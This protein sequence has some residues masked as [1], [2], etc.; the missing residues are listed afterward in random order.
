MTTGNEMSGETPRWEPGAARNAVSLGRHR[1]SAALGSKRPRA[2]ARAI[3]AGVGGQRSI[4]S[5]F[6]ILFAVPLISLVALYAYLASGTAGAAFAKRDADTVN[7]DLGSPSSSLYLQL[8][9]ERTDTLVWQSAHGKVPETGLDAQ[10]KLTDSAVAAFTAA[11][12]AARGAEPPAGQAAVAAVVEK[13]GAV[14]GIRK[15]VDAGTVAPLTAFQAYNNVIDTA[16][17]IAVGALTNPDT[18]V[19]FYEQGL[20]TG[21]MGQSL[22]YVDREASLVGGALAAG[23]TMSTA[24]YQLFLEALDEQ[25]FLERAGQTPV[26]WQQYPD[27]YP[28]VFASPAYVQFAGLEDKI[29]AA[30]PGVRL[31]VSAAGWQA[32][33]GKFVPLLLRAEVTSRQEVT[34]GSTHE[35]NVTLLRLILV[36]GA[37]LIAVIVSAALLLL[38][39]RR[40][41]RELTDL[42]EAARTLAEERL[43]ALVRRLRAGDDVDVDAEAPPLALD[44]RTREVTETANAFSAVRHTAV[45]A[46]A[47]QAKLRK[48]VNNVFRSLARR[49]QSLLQR[50]LRMLDEM[51]DVTE[52]PDALAQLFRLDHLTTRMRRQAEGL[53]IL[54][55]A[56]P[57][58]GWPRPVLL[59]D[60]LRAA[61]GEIEDYLRVDL[62]VYSRDYLIGAAVADVTHLLAELLE[63][64]VMHSPAASR[65]QVRGNRVA[66]GFLVE[67]EDRGL[68]IPPAVL[69]VLNDQLAGP[70]EFDLA[71]SDRLGLFVV[72]RLAARRD[73]RVALR[74]SRYGTVAA[75]LLPYNL[76]AAED[77]AG[78][79]AAAISSD[80]S[81]KNKLYVICAEFTTDPMS[82]RG[83]VAWGLSMARSPL[84]PGRPGDRVA[85]TRC[86]SRR[87]AR[88]SSRSTFARRSTA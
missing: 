84:S 1:V 59:V 46:A 37:G 77:T 70:L 60:V 51:E 10:R 27:P 30:G 39:G 17:P 65:V 56:A 83:G 20:G 57:G 40:I 3:G 35:G 29:A 21:E 50:Q 82:G 85:V 48:G 88:T 25:R 23:G 72:G 45:E 34:S 4:R 15:Q 36:G 31:P 18:S 63:N 74:D 62:L 55:G 80:P 86:G 2:L 11:A 58:R 12:R 87:K 14:G 81:T 73:I 6:L 24:A 9:T 13:L 71:D 68:G 79:I 52:D 49:N 19:V 61:I 78:K 26:Y 67:I 44:T 69:T 54:S 43:P 41:T 76:I 5:T 33:L 8:D 38:F 53:I 75:V 28:P 16:F 32:S 66:S 64:A 7:K 47:G 22:E 42:R